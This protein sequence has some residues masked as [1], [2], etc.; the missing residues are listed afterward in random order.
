MFFEVR[1]APA[2]IQIEPEAYSEKSSENPAFLLRF[3]VIWGP[4]M[5]PTWVRFGRKINSKIHPE[6]RCESL[7]KSGSKSAPKAGRVRQDRRR[8]AKGKHANMQTYV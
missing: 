4:K 7:C 1:G 8:S 6:I 3:F 2:R 5:D